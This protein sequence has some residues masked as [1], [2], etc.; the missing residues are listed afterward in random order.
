VED[1]DCRMRIQLMEAEAEFQ[2]EGR[3]IM[4]ADNEHKLNGAGGG[5]GCRG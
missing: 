4:G 1:E 5:W 2:S 3:E